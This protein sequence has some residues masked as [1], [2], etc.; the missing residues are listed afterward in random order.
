LYLI[1]IKNIDE[2]ATVCEE[3]YAVLGTIY[4]SDIDVQTLTW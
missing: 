1:I 3:G 2:E 4:P